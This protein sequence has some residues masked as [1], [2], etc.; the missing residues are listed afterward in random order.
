MHKSKFRLQQ[1]VGEQAFLVD[2]LKETRRQNKL[3]SLATEKTVEQN[4]ALDSFF[5]VN[6]ASNSDEYNAARDL[7]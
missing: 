3:M 5:A 4:R 7:P 6:C 1:G 2:S